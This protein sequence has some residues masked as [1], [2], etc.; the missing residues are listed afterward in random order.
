MTLRAPE[1]DPTK[2]VGTYLNWKEWNELIS[3]PNILCIDTRNDYEVKIGTFKGATDPKTQVFTQFKEYVETL[4]GRENEKIAMMCTGGIRCEKA[5][6]YMLA[7]GFKHVYHLKGGILQYLEDVPEGESLWEG[8]CF[9]FDQ[10]VGVG[11]GVEK[12]GYHMCFGCRMPLSDEELKSHHYE[13]GVTCDYC[14]DKVSEKKKKSLRQRQKQ[15]E[16]A[17]SRG[18]EH[19]GVT[20]PTHP[21]NLTN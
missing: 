15:I 7:H 11:H 14:Y 21:N 8:E 3:D 18:L 17:R 5:S 16:I 2:Q 10:R 9:V 20:R 19:I 6:A 13:E 4:K 1:A 12:G